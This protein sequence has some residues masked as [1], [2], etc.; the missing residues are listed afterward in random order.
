MH[1]MLL[2]D[3]AATLIRKGGSI[4]TDHG[5][6]MGNPQ[7]FKHMCCMFKHAELLMAPPRYH[8]VILHLAQCL[9]QKCQSISQH[10]HCGQCDCK[11]HAWICSREMPCTSSCS[12]HTDHQRLG[13]IFLASIA[14]LSPRLQA[15]A[16]PK[17]P[18]QARLQRSD[19]H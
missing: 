14:H 8:T 2:L 3:H 13:V 4:Q 12:G 17:G 6:G 16:D 15:L 10:Q 9:L 7:N 18:G 19:I 5:S 11:S 1:V